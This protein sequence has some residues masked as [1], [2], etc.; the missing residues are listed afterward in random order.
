MK[1]MQEILWKYAA[2]KCSPEEKAKTE[3]YLA[4]H[5][6]IQVELDAMIEVESLLSD[7]EATSPSLRF[8]E[9]VMSNLPDVY[10]IEEM[11]PLVKPIWAKIFLAAIGTFFLAIFLI[12]KNPG[13]ETPDLPYLDH[14]MQLINSE[15]SLLPAPTVQL[16]VLIAL[17]LATL[18]ILDNFILR[19]KQGML[20]L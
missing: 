2:G 15:I 20:M 9:N 1:D 13:A 12:P 14:F 17:S 18:V 5:P 3:T 16:S 7:M 19:K 8:S 10:A 6:A 4:D 11:E